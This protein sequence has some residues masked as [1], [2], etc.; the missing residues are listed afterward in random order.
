MRFSDWLTFDDIAEQ[1]PKEP[2]LFQ[3]KTREGLLSYPR[4][5]SAMFYYG[6]SEDLNYGL[7][8][9]SRDILPRLKMTPETLFARWSI[10]TFLIATASTAIST[11]SGPGPSR[12]RSPTRPSSWAANWRAPPGASPNTATD[13]CPGPATPP[14][15]RTRTSCPARASISRK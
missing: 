2:G 1:V 4:G 11:P 9:F 6:Y 14:S 3:I 13:G 8:K 7:Q 15:I 10:N 5:K 12:C